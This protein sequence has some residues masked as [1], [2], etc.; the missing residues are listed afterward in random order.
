ME[1][2]A[3]ARNTTTPRRRSPALYRLSAIALAFATAANAQTWPP[4]PPP[5][6]P[7]PHKVAWVATASSWHP[8]TYPGRAPENAIRT[9]LTQN[10]TWGLNLAAQHNTAVNFMW[11]SANLTPLPGTYYRI[12]FKEEVKISA[13]K[14]WNYNEGGAQTYARRGVHEVDIYT[15]LS[16]NPDPANL[17][18][19]TFQLTHFFEGASGADNDPGC[20]LLEF[21]ATL[22]AQYFM[23][24]VK[25][26][27]HDNPVYNN[28]QTSFA[29][30]PFTGFS[31][32]QFYTKPNPFTTSV[33]GVAQTAASLHTLLDG[34]PPASL[35]AYWAFTDQMDNATAWTNA[36]GFG[37]SGLYSFADDT[38][39]VEA[40]GLAPG[41]QHVFRFRAV[42]PGGEVL[43]SDPGT[44]TT[45]TGLPEIKLLS[46]AVASES[47]V[48][49]N[50]LLEWAGSG[51]T[52]D[53]TVC[54][55]PVDGGETL[56]GWTSAGGASM[57]VHRAAGEWPVTFAVNEVNK[58]YYC[59]A[60]ATSGSGLTAAAPGSLRFIVGKLA[61]THVKTLYW[62]GG[63]EHIPPLTPLPAAPGD[64][65]GTWDTSA[66]NW[67]I[68]PFGTLYVAWEDGA[69]KVAVLP[70]LNTLGSANILLK[71]DVS[72]NQIRAPF[73]LSPGT[74]GTMQYQFVS[75]SGQ[76][77]TVTLGG[78]RP[79]LHVFTEPNNR[80]NPQNTGVARLLV[81]GNDVRLAAPRGFEK[82]G[83]GRLNLAFPADLVFGRI[84]VEDAYGDNPL[85]LTTANTSSM[86]NVEAFHFRCH[87]QF[88]FNWPSAQ[89]NKFNAD[90]V[91]H[92]AGI[93]RATPTGFA[94][95]RNLRQI[96]LGNQGVLS[97]ENLSGANTLTL[98]HPTQ[99][100][101]RGADGVG[102]LYV[103]SAA[104]TLAGL[105][106]PNGPPAHTPLPWTLSVNGKPL[107]FNALRQ[108]EEAPVIGAPADLQD[109]TPGSWYILGD[110]ATHGAYDPFNGPLPSTTVASLGIW[111]NS[112]GMV[113][114]IADGAALEITSG[115]L[116]MHVGGIRTL[117]GGS[118]TTPANELCILQTGGN[119]NDNHFKIESA[120]TG[121]MRVVKGG[122][123][124]VDFA[125][126]STNTYAGATFVNGGILCLDKPNNTVAIP[127]ALVVGGGA[128]VQFGAANPNA[129]GNNQMRSDAPLTILEDGVLRFNFII[130]PWSGGQV[131]NGAVTN[132]N[133][134]IY[135]YRGNNAPGIVFAGPGYGLVFANGG[136]V[137]QLDPS[138]SNLNLS[139]LTDLLCEA[140]SSNQAMF[141]TSTALSEN[142]QRLRL[143]NTAAPGVRKPRV[144]DVRK[145][146]ALLP[147]QPELVMNIPLETVN[148][149]EVEIVKKGGGAM[150]LEQFS[151]R[152]RGSATVLD[153]SLLVN[154]PYATNTTYLVN[155]ISG[156]GNRVRNLPSTAGI[157]ITQPVAQAETFQAGNKNWVTQ[158]GFPGETPPA[159]MDINLER[160][161]WWPGV[162]NLTFLACG[163]LGEAGVTV[164]GSGALGGTGGVAGNVAV[165]AGG[166]FRP[167]TPARPHAQFHVGQNLVFAEGAVWEVCISNGLGE[168]DANL[169]RVA[170]G[171]TLAGECA[172][173][174]IA[175][176]KRP[177]GVWTIATYGGVA[178]GKMSAP[179]GCKVRIDEEKK[180]IQLVSS[181][182]GT[183]LMVR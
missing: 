57:T 164:S 69:D 98:T 25:S 71:T 135:F 146:A 37:S 60:F 51:P 77:R 28:P 162:G 3:T 89:P 147:E 141:V 90:A 139:L 169:A 38:Y 152:F 130:G 157:Y 53:I 127:N 49:A 172:P 160:N 19:W 44:F 97:L 86:G 136:R 151:G 2:P 109:W 114:P 84:S 156:T 7:I 91:F 75:E 119:N 165:E 143:S 180:I 5:H 131:F 6:I 32:I 166:T 21:P 95:N 154:G 121:A 30:D 12:D 83:L 150:A 99:G 39:T 124:R 161:P 10:S 115:H 113:L 47:A 76:T 145:A 8:G 55:G 31:K 100:I 93:S 33:S 175:G 40:A 171:I 101:H 142:S 94:G 35:A 163:A 110:P 34:S 116:S 118:V 123:G 45:K 170:G 149:G 61:A 82:T 132:H 43:W 48:V 106:V 107:Q 183:L 96:V 54:W 41:T 117:A 58:P 70:A 108:L 18:A 22:R 88:N 29:S 9:E 177:K 17:A 62:G 181:E 79:M 14:L 23:L 74:G 50:V 67:S 87:S 13:L 81:F 173:E 159:P 52:A 11:L 26:T 68:D 104:A 128:E 27:H 103:P 20:A 1:K 46:V 72:L 42:M 24:R 148:N 80:A 126:T 122:M 155:T 140:A 92:L 105:I 111:N 73:N 133:G 176:V 137:E 182:A 120:L 15:A 138:T 65:A 153:G 134:K 78:D 112:N 178:E 63:S 125:G 174:F 167:G 59:R 36:A 64:L 4:A 168:N 129:R 85:V 16:G 158:I 102:T 56:A 179:Q 144:F 66:K